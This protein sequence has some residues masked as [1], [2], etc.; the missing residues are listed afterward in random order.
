MTLLLIEWVVVLLTQDNIEEL[1]L[2][3][4]GLIPVGLEGLKNIVLEKRWPQRLANNMLYGL[5][6]E[7]GRYA[8]VIVA[9]LCITSLLDKE[10]ALYAMLFCG[11]FFMAVAVN[12]I[13]N[14]DNTNK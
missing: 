6:I 10:K 9:L 4:A 11:N 13:A 1:R 7:M 5:I 12:T 14:W 3:L 2:V 8:L